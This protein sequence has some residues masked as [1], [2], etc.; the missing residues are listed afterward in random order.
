MLRDQQFV[1]PARP[2][3]VSVPKKADIEVCFICDNGYIV[4]TT[5]AITS[6]LQSKFRR[7]VCHIYIVAA[8]LSRENEDH[9]KHFAASDVAVTVIRS[10]ARDLEALHV[11]NKKAMCVAS[12][13]A[14]LKFC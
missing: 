12:P 10:S 3:T 4:P 13:A 6:L 14:L 5:V 11:Y 8:D 1:V 2:A 9:F 7:T